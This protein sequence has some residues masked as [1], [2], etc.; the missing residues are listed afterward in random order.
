MLADDQ[1][2]LARLLLDGGLRRRFLAEQAGEE[3]DGLELGADELASLR[4]IDPAALERVAASLISKRRRAVEA[5]VPHAARLWPALGDRYVE[6]LAIRPARVDALDA[7]IGPGPSELLRMLPDLLRSAR[8]DP[9]AASWTGDLLAL[10]LARACSR[11]DGQTRSLRCRHPVHELLLACDR[12]W[13]SVDLEP[14][15]CD[16]RVEPTRLRWRSVGDGATP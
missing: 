6:L 5:T 8:C 13:L 15:R 9:A 7:R 3:L 14:G 10:E 2:A 11:R 16:Y 1:E 12:G 4:A